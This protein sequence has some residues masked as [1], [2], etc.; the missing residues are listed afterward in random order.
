MYLGLIPSLAANAV[1]ITEIPAD[2]ASR[3][4][5]SDSSIALEKL[6]WDRDADPVAQGVERC[7]AAC[8]ALEVVADVL[9]A[10]QVGAAEPGLDDRGSRSTRARR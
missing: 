10:L 7:A 2:A 3:L 8:E 1:G 4:V 5:I 6:T 9:W